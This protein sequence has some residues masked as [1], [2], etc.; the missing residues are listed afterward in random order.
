M[1]TDCKSQI[2][3]V[4]TWALDLL[5]VRDLPQEGCK[6]RKFFQFSGLAM[7]SSC[8]L[9]ADQKFNGKEKEINPGIRFAAKEQRSGKKQM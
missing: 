9:S 5:L 3:S 8:F 2:L 1:W 6:Q 7:T 4:N